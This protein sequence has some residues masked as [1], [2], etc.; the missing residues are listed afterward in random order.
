MPDFGIFQPEIS[1]IMRVKFNFVE[2]TSTRFIIIRNSNPQDTQLFLEKK[3]NL[4]FIFKFIIIN[5]K[6]ESILSSYFASRYV[7]QRSRL[8]VESYTKFNLVQL[9]DFSADCFQHISDPH[10][11]HSHSESVSFAYS[12]RLTSISHRSRHFPCSSTRPTTF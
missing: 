5:W 7:T 3:R 9:T 1:Y 8:Q 6:L 4:I 10:H 2:K 12:L 11:R